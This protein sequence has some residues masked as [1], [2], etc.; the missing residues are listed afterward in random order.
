[1][2]AAPGQATAFELRRKLRANLKTLR[3]SNQKTG[4]KTAVV[5]NT[6][7]SGDNGNDANSL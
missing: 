5:K 4:R 1:M 6:I 2:N 7:G 3:N